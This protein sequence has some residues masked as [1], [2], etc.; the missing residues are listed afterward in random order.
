[1][2]YLNLFKYEMKTILKDALNL[3]MLFYPFLILIL[4]GVVIPLALKKMDT[5]SALVLIIL[6]MVT[7]TI[8]SFLIGAMLGFSFLEN[9][10]EKTILGLSVTPLR[11]QGYTIFKIIYAYVFSIIGNIIIIGGLKIIASDS[12]VIEEGSIHLLENISYLN[13][14]AFSLTSSLFAPLFALII[15]AIAKNKI[16]G[17]ALMKSSAIIIFIP[18]LTL[19]PFF[20]DSKQ[21]LLGFAPNFWSVK[22]MINVATNNNSNFN[23]YLY[24]LI[25]S[26]FS[27]LLIIFAL[28][29]F[30]KKINTN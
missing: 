26:I 29:L 17:F 27:V 3:F 30:I 11:V 23:F 19:I 28:K 9:K 2:K 7:L 10:D 6:L 4:M 24:M 16:E 21:F 8:G 25:G 5:S 12:Y 13:I 1:M 14:I 15:A 20:Q 22:G 18:M